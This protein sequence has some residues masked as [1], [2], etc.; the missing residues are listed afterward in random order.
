MGTGSA[1]S[2]VA[3][4][5]AEVPEWKILVLEAGDQA[6]E[7][8][9]IPGLSLFNLPDGI[10]QSWNYRIEPQKHAMFN[11]ENRVRHSFRELKVNFKRS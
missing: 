4:R 8:T 11:Y 7:E 6:P 10:K 5:L 9:K 3:A 1:G 2:A